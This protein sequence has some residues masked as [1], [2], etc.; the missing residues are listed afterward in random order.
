MY[1]F[2]EMF[3]LKNILHFRLKI[4]FV[5]DV[6]YNLKGVKYDHKKLKLIL[7]NFR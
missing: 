3:Y 5:H 7:L 4:K 2:Q 6:H 1:W